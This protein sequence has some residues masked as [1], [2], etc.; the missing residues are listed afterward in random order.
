MKENTDVRENTAKVR[1]GDTMME[2]DLAHHAPGIQKIETQEVIITVEQRRTG[3][4]R[5][6]KYDSD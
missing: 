4:E 5:E 3:T 6:T 2:S 1:E